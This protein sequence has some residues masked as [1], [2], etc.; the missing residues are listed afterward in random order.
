MKRHED[1]RASNSHRSGYSRVLDSGVLPTVRLS[2]RTWICRSQ[3]QITDS[4][5][6]ATRWF[7]RFTSGRFRSTVSPSES[8]QK[9]EFVEHRP[10]LDSCRCGSFDCSLPSSHCEFGRWLSSC[11]RVNLKYVPL[12]V[13]ACAVVWYFWGW[14]RP[15]KGQ[16]SLTLLTQNNIDQF[17]LDFNNATDRPRLVLLL[18]PT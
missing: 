3:R 15:P 4:E 1:R 13:I 10:F 18:S 5:T 17:K 12:C 9:T 6:L 8:V 16:P 2:W 7:I 11:M 14:S